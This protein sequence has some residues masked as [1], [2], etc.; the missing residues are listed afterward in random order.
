MAI[1]YE[2]LLLVI[3]SVVTVWVWNKSDPIIA[4]APLPILEWGFIGGVSAVLFRAAYR[5]GFETVELDLATWSLVKPLVGAVMGAIVYFIAVSG[6]QAL[7]GK[8]DIPP[9]T[10]VNVL[11]FI[12]GFSDRF[13][14]GLFRRFMINVLHEPSRERKEG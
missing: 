5:R 2:T 9:N 7:S 14:I 10:F 8:S 13:S 4:Y 3:I 1:L 6:L 12:A 11:A